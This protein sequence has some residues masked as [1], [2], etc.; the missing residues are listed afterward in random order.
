MSALSP[1]G[2][3]GVIAF[4]IAA[5]SLV[6][7]AVFGTAGSGVA[8][9]QAIPVNTGT[10]TM[11]GTPQQGSTLTAAEGTWSNSPTSY[12]YAWSRC[13]TNG[14]SCATITGATAKTYVLSAADVG[15]TMRV[16]VTAKNA[17]GS[18]NEVSVPSAVIAA[19]VAPK[20]TVAPAISGTATVDSILSV[21]NGT[22][23]NSPTGY[24]YGWTRC[25]QNG[26]ACSTI[27]GADGPQYKV[28]SADVG[29]TLRAVVTAKNSTGE[30][31]VTSSQTSVIP[32]P[33]TTTTTTTPTPAPTTGCPSGS[34]V[35]QASQLSL[36]ARLSVGNQTISPGVVTPSTSTVQVRVKVTACNGRPV[37]GALVF[38]VAVPYNQFDGLEAPTGADG[39]VTLTMNQ[40]AG[41]PASTH[42][43]RLA[44]FLRARKPGGSTTGDISTH[45]LVTF[46]VS[47]R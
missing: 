31:P 36:P 22:W 35:I 15:H 10:P 7:G 46:P 13:D 18:A 29:T 4:A 5:A 17:D 25:D 47:L 40:R 23:D 33:T 14:N 9:S 30:T 28:T 26:N 19:A 41:F 21:T 42:Q 20:N 44:V 12:T 8:A 27:N 34:G 3:R 38:A 1:R 39:T 45:R 2:R 16:T 32:S 43:Q 11:S 24:T 37:Q 6:I